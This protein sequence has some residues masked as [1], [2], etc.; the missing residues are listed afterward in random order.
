M[1]PPRGRSNHSIQKNGFGP[2]HSNHNTKRQD[3]QP[4]G[5]SQMENSRTSTSSQWLPRTFDT[6][7]ECPKAHITA[8]PVVR[9]AQV[10]TGS[11]RNIPVLVQELVYGSKSGVGT[12]SQ[13]VDRDHELL[14]SSKEALWSR[15][16]T[17]TSQGVATHVLQGTGSKDESLVQKP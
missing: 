9:C 1:T 17:R 7:I 3:L 4:R 2:G 16:C 10:L 8:I 11:S 15:K 6:F 12:S 5:K 14:P 13:L